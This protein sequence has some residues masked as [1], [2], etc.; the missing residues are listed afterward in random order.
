MRG[1]KHCD[2]TVRLGKRMPTQ[3]PANVSTEGEVTTPAALTLE[4]TGQNAPGCAKTPPRSS[5]GT[6]LS[7]H[8]AASARS[9]AQPLQP[10]AESARVL[11]TSPNSKAKV[12]GRACSQHRRKG[13]F[14]RWVGLRAAT[15]PTIMYTPA[16]IPEEWQHTR[17]CTLTAGSFRQCGCQFQTAATGP[18]HRAVWPRGNGGRPS[19]TRI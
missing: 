5:F 15:R 9:V 17:G 13:H 19:H 3:N 4:S 11:I 8:E 14:H 7:W 2:G 16:M 10:A 1:R 12:Q 18:L 6:R